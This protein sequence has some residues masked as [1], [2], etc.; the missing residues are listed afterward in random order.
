MRVDDDPSRPAAG[1]L[2]EDDRHAVGR[3]FDD[4][5]VEAPPD[6]LLDPCGHPLDGLAVAADR[7]DPAGLAPLV[8]EAVGVAR[9]RVV[10]TLLGSKR[11]GVRGQHLGPVVGHED[12]VL[13]PNAAVALP[14]AARLDGDDVT[15]DERAAREVERRVLVHVEAD[16]VAEPVEEPVEQ[17]LTRLLRAAVWDSRPASTTSEAIVCSSRPVTP[18][19]IAGITRS[20]TSRQ[21]RW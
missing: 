14:V 13:E 6:A 7:R 2:A 8:D 3:P 15:G 21:R 16:T 20:C 12:E 9:D 5:A 19:R 10:G 18:G 17:H 11:V 1:E 4:D